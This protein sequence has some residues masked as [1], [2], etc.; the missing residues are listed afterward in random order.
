MTR[1]KAT[2]TSPSQASCDVIGSGIVWSRPRPRLAKAKRNTV[3][4][5][6][7]GEKNATSELPGLIVLKKKTIKHAE[8]P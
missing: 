7:P 6:L 2:L 8:I 4:M 1:S 3:Y 5:Q